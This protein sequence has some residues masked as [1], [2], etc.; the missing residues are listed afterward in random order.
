VL[1]WWCGSGSIVRA[2]WFNTLHV[3]RIFGLIN[4][5]KGDGLRTQQDTDIS[6]LY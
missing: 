3:L 1:L 5:S 2:C 6:T 4:A